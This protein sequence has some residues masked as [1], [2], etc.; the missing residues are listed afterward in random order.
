MGFGFGLLMGL[1]GGLFVGW[2]LLPAPK[3]VQDWWA[4]VNKPT[5]P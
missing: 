2:L 3:A 4:G 5:L 1:S